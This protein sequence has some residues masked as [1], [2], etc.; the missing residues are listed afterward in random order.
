MNP[1]I[2]RLRAEQQKV[3]DRI[4]SLQDRD[5]ELTNQI[6]DL[7][8]IDIVG[9]VR[10][11]GYTLESFSALMKQLQDNPIPNNTPTEDTQKEAHEHENVPDT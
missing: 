6:R 3:R 2:R 10:A 1:K 11:E 4:A 8:N 9:L 7:E 5:K